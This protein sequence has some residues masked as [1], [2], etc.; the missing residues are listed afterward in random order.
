M[1]SLLVV[2]MSYN[3]LHKIPTQIF[4]KPSKYFDKCQTDNFDKVLME[5]FDS[6][7]GA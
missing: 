5:N 7:N 1:C 3:C 6:V 4:D 2:A